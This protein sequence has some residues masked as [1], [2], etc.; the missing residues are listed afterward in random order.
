MRKG[1]SVTDHDR[2]SLR[3][4]CGRLR[5]GDEATLAR[6]ISLVES[7]LELGTVLHSS[8]HAATGEADVIGITGPPGVGKSTLIDALVTT[9]RSEGERVAVVAV[10]PSSPLSG[11][12]LLGDRTRMGRHTD[13]PGVF[14]R[15]VSARGHLGGLSLNTLKILDLI[16]AAGWG[17]VI[18]ETVG[19]GQSETEV[20]DVA[21]ISVVLNAPGLGDHVQSIKAGILEIADVLVVNKSDMPQAQ[22]TER[23]LKA[24]LKLRRASAQGVP[25]VSTV[26]HEQ[27]G[28]TELLDAIRQRLA[29]KLGDP[30]YERRH[31]RCRKLL[32]QHLSESVK[33]WMLNSRS[34]ETQE[35]IEGV[36]CGVID[37]ETALLRVMQAGARGD[38]S[39]GQ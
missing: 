13:D 11:G 32:A 37:A 24:M 27:R 18:L 22:S 28:I 31:V 8:I 1:V 38:I 6:A 14:I 25:V 21:D 12:A 30:R 16:D 17:T 36:S 39:H 29:E 15:S 7:G 26:A 3:E 5:A 10:D 34:P 35:L 2:G 20:A 9:L 4:F 33:Q 19:A 23:E